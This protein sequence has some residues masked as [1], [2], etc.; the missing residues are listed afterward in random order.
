M[1][2]LMNAL[3]S[4]LFVICYKLVLCATLFTCMDSLPISTAQLTVAPPCINV[5][6]PSAKIDYK[7]RALD[8]WVDTVGTAW[9]PCVSAA[10]TYTLFQTR[11]YSELVAH[12]CR[13]LLR[14]LW[15]NDYWAVL[16]NPKQPPHME[17]ASSFSACIKYV[18]S[19]Y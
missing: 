18:L 19:I 4:E 15:T 17:G 7:S 16:I 10:P 1:Q 8:E 3:S 13:L 11:R 9:L 12:A 14:H 6:R 5:I 2:F